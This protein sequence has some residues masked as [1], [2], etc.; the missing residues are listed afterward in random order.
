M[1]KHPA[2]LAPAPE[3]IPNY[4]RASV[5]ARALGRGK[6]FVERRAKRERW[7]RRWAGNRRTYR[8]PV[9]LQTLC[10]G[11]LRGGKSTGG[12]TGFKI[13]KAQ[14]NE[15][16]RAQK[17]FSALCALATAKKKSGY[18]AAL[19]HV[20]ICFDTNAITLRQWAEA[21][22]KN[23]FAGLLEHKRG[24]VGRKASQGKARR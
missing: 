8:V 23:G 17:R 21:W 16:A 7:P 22:K 15:V 12:L 11:A 3:I 19:K 14:I 18:E 24:R 5:I 13:S 20:A 2:N 4:F 6:K 9:E 1:K 10:L